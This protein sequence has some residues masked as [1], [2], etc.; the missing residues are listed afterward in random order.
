MSDSKQVKTDLGCVKWFDTKK[1]YGFLT[2]LESKDDVFIHYS[3]IKTEEDVYKMLY[4]GEYISYTSKKDDQGRL[5]TENV[6]GVQG[7]ILLC[8][9][10]FFKRFNSNNRKSSR[11]N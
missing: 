10:E 9:N 11:N 4:E 6:T 8:E 1:G 7:G 2:N 3:S 5:V